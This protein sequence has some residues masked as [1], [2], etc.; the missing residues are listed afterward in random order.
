MEEKQELLGRISTGHPEAEAALY[1]LF[2]ARLLRVSRHF[3][4]EQD[5]E[6]SDIVRDT[7]QEAFIDIENKAFRT[8]IFDGL[9]QICL[10]R[11][12][13]RLNERARTLAKLED[14]L[15]E[16][17]ARFSYGRLPAPGPLG[18]SLARQCVQDGLLSQ[19]K[20]HIIELK[21]LQGMSLARIGGTLKLPLGAVLS[22]LCGARADQRRLTGDL[23]F[24]FKML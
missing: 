7:L 10:G 20:L 11:C 18:P 19:E 1:E 9:R 24:R 14:E 21:D 15:E 17:L 22:R 12:Y 5:E 2:Q 4:G 6:A 3:F 16:S 23:T 13:E 8:P